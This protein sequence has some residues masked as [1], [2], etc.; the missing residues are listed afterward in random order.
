MST[1]IGF[2]LGTHAAI[3]ASKRG[4]YPIDGGQVLDIGSNSNIHGSS[5]VSSSGPLNSSSKIN[6]MFS[7]SALDDLTIKNVL[8]STEYS[9]K[10]FVNAA[11][12]QYRNCDF[13]Q[14]TSIMFSYLSNDGISLKSFI[15]NGSDF[16]QQRS[17][18][19]KLLVVNYTEKSFITEKNVI[20][21]EDFISEANSTMNDSPNKDY[22]FHVLCSEV[23]SYLSKLSE[24]NEAFDVVYI[25]SSCVASFLDN[26]CS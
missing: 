11:I 17:L 18:L 2:T 12:R 24:D 22:L 15:L 26:N 13:N 5:L 9:L 6:E 19:G 8:L 20:L 23:V 25:D 10:P 4:F 16:S 7:S 14:K 1:I 21:I 3:F